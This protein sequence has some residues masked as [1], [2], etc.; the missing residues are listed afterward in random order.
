MSYKH[1]SLEERY[2]IDAVEKVAEAVDKINSRPRKCPGQKTLYEV[3][4]KLSGIGARILIQ[5]IRQR[6]EFAY[7]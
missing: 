4:D 3:F 1:I 6:C 7:N 5:G 2:Y